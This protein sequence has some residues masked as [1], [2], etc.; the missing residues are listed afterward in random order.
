MK[1]NSITMSPT[2]NESITK[3]RVPLCVVATEDDEIGSV[4]SDLRSSTS[5][6]PPASILVPVPSI[7]IKTPLS[8]YEARSTELSVATAA[9][10]E[11][12]LHDHEH[13]HGTPLH[14]EQTS[15]SVKSNTDTNSNPGF[16]HTQ[17]GGLLLA[18]KNMPL[19]VDEYV[20]PVVS[21][22]IRGPK[23]SCLKRESSYNSL[24]QSSGTSRSLGASGK[25]RETATR[26]VSPATNT[27][28]LLRTSSTVSFQSVNVR[29]YERTLGDNPSCS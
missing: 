8:H 11:T 14:H 29:E 6:P 9:T 1:I 7:S 28:E 15:S 21:S 23:K 24:G 17:Q 10:E 25:K 27:R 5:T 13:E 2:R 20:V 18:P 4:L 22:P 12:H 3:N 26:P 19:R 16:Y